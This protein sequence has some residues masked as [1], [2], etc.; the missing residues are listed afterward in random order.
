MLINR[1]QLIDI[2]S[3]VAPAFRSDKG[4]PIMNHFWFTGTKV[5]VYSEHVAISVPFET[6]F[7]GAVA[8]TLLSLL[9]TSKAKEVEL[10][11]EG[12]AL[13]VKAGSSKYKLGMMAPEDFI[14][15]MP[16]WDG[17]VLP[18]DAARFIE[19]LE[20]CMFSVTTDT[21]HSEYT[22]VTFVNE[23]DALHLYGTD[24]ITI[25]QAIL[26]MGAHEA[27]LPKRITVR[28]EFCKQFLRVAG[29]ARK[30]KMKLTDKYVLAQHEGVLIYGRVEEP[31]ASPIE[32]GKIVDQHFPDEMHNKMFGIP[33]RLKAILERACII[34]VDAVDATK[35]QVTVKD[36]TMRFLSASDRGE[37]RD[38]LS[39]PKHPDFNGTIDPKRVL[40]ASSR[41]DKF[42]MTSNLV[43]MKKGNI[44]HLISAM[45]S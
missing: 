44:T 38:T 31:D 40:D 7:R 36:D 4:T 18:V 6:E 35:T 42:L 39:I 30:I 11:P 33:S 28:Q 26:K 2:L 9:R 19:G 22:G 24:R 20:A 16:K 17:A 41:F 13:R 14:F 29:G 43:I 1:K 37:V 45:F 34:A 3:E 27:K 23:R 32:F 15:D 5:M 10:I 8:Q 21:S 12:E 25:T